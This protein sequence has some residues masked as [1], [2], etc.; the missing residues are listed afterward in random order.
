MSLSIKQAS[1][2]EMSGKCSISDWSVLFRLSSVWLLISDLG[3]FC[4][5]PSSILFNRKRLLTSWQC[6]VERKLPLVSGGY[7]L[8]QFGYSLHFSLMLIWVTGRFL[9]T[10]LPKRRH[11]SSPKVPGTLLYSILQHEK[12]FI[13]SYTNNG[14]KYMFN[15]SNSY[16]EKLFFSTLREGKTELVMVVS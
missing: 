9:I 10:S 6:V 8:L 1:N 15:N 4:N 16:L 13:W 14:K 3:T 5:Y 2:C 7:Y 11:L 12:I